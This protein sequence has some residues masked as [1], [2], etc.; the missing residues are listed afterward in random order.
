M[1]Q[2]SLTVEFI[3]TLSDTSVQC[4]VHRGTI[5]LFSSPNLRNSKT[6]F[7]LGY[8]SLACNIFLVECS[9]NNTMDLYKRKIHA[10]CFTVSGD[11]I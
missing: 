9:I 2:K 5:N 4:I 1:C 10:T 6:I 11:I 8:F 3:F 7:E